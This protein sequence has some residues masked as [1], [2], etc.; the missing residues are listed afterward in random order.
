MKIS[1]N[2]RRETI[3]VQLEP[4]DN[5][6]PRTVQAALRNAGVPFS[7]VSSTGRWEIRS[8]HLEQLEESLA[9]FSPLWDAKALERLTQ[10]RQDSRLKSIVDGRASDS[11]TDWNPR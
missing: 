10:L 4:K 9:R 11:T 5:L 3:D 2:V 8:Q 7:A 1:L 6:S